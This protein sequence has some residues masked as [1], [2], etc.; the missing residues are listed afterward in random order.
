MTDEATTKRLQEAIGDCR[1][2]AR[3]IQ[4]AMEAIET[5]DRSEYHRLDAI[6]QLTFAMA[7]LRNAKP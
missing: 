5:P 3:A 6:A 1:K 4:K 2:A 7:A